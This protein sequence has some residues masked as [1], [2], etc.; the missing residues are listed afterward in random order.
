MFDKK[1][2]QETYA[3]LHASENILKEVLKRTTQTP[4]K[5]RRLS[6]AAL[7]IAA[8]LIL[9]LS[10]T[11]FAYVGFTQYENPSAMLQAF[12][13]NENRQAVEEHEYYN[14]YGSYIHS[15]ASDR[16]ALDD[17]AA[18]WLAADLS[19]AD[20]SLQHGD[21]TLTVEA[22]LFDEQTN[23]ALL[24][25]K[26]ENPSGVTGYKVFDDGELW[27]DP[28][29]IDVNVLFPS[30][31]ETTYIDNA[32]TTNTVLYAC[33]YLAFG[34]DQI[35]TLEVELLDYESQE[36]ISDTI[37]LTA[38]QSM[39]VLSLENGNIVLSPIALRLNTGAFD[40]TADDLSLIVL[41]YADGTAYTV[42]SD[43][44]GDI[45][46][47]DDTWVQNTAYALSAQDSVSYL[48]NRLVDVNNVTSITINEKNHS[49][50]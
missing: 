44:D 33:T 21:Y 41:H 16:A 40:C 37:T 34:T 49:V 31:G 36:S 32:R 43:P 26:L 1:L 15:P 23:C 7:P 9:A 25:Y 28:E 27:F 3:S 17:D 5:L 47:A 46:I 4:K 42:I 22:T 50:A 24:Y 11:A 20:L 14:A 45:A 13:G 19:A 2:Y 10:T 29:T 38:A 48:L 39:P 18:A 6:R 30:S 35:K 8:V 12:F